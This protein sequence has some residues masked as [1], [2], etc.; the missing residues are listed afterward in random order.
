MSKYEGYKQLVVSSGG[1]TSPETDFNST[2]KAH[3]FMC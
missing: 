2:D 3:T 1:P